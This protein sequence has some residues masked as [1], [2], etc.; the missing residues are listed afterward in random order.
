MRYLTLSNLKKTRGA[1]ALLNIIE[2]NQ[3]VST[4]WDQKK[5]TRKAD[6]NGFEVR[7][8]GA[9]SPPSFRLWLA[10]AWMTSFFRRASSLFLPVVLLIPVSQRQVFLSHA[11]FIES[12][13]TKIL[14]TAILLAF[15]GLAFPFSG[16]NSDS[17]PLQTR[18]KTPGFIFFVEFHRSLQNSV[19]VYR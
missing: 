9:P 7:Y 18:I 5:M 1:A 11:L 3:S 2:D 13:K 14:Y 4:F 10:G 17:T 16:R 6:G 8:A 19:E 12:R 15:K